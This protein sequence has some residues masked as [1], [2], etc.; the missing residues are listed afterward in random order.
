MPRPASLLAVCAG[1][2]ASLG[3][4]R[5]ATTSAIDKRPVAGPV[6]VDALGLVPDTQVDGAHHGG[7][8]QAL[9]VYAQ[10]DADHW[11]AAL[12]RDIVPGAFGENLRTRGVDV[13]GARIGARWRIGSIEVQVTAPRIPCATF[14]TFWEV[15]DLV[16]RFVSAGRPG[17]YLRVLVGGT[18]E[19]G[20]DVEVLEVPDHDVTIA[21]ALRIHTRDRHEAGR[22]LAAEGL[23][24]RARTWAEQQVAGRR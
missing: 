16:A 8:D 14:A 2:S 23:A 9:Y 13:T 24:V 17:A 12:Q 7:P 15:P 19:A 1:E 11:V 3:A 10:E 21:D 18:I 5:R 6:R 20:D 4:D 22:L